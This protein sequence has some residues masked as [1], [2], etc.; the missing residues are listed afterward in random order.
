MNYSDTRYFR[1]GRAG[2]STKQ[3]SLYM[4]D[5]Q[6]DCDDEVIFAILSI[7][8]DTFLVCCCLALDEN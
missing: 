3:M 2:L 5:F 4:K 8:H 1:K 6:N 7:N